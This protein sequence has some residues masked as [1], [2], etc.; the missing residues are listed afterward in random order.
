LG[1]ALGLEHE[2]NRS[3]RDRYVQV[4]PENVV[5]GMLH[6]FALRQTANCSRYDFAS[7]M[8]YGPT[9]FSS[10]GLAT[11][12]PQPEYAY[13]RDIMGL[14]ADLTPGDAAEVR[15]LYTGVCEQPDGGGGREGAGGIP[16]TDAST[17]D[18]TGGPRSLRTSDPARWVLRGS[19]V[20][21]ADVRRGWNEGLEIVTSARTADEQFVV[22]SASLPGVRQSFQ[23]AP[24]FPAEYVRAKWD[25]GY[26]IQH[27]VHGVGGWQVLMAD[28]LGWGAQSWRKSP[29]WPKEEIQAL[30][31]EGKRITTVAHGDGQ[32][33]VALTEGTGI[34]AQSWDTSDAPA[35]N[36][37]AERR[38]A[39]GFRVTGLAW[40][41]GSWVIVSS[42]GTDLDR[43][44]MYWGAAFP[45]QSIRDRWAEGY[46]ITAL[47]RSDAQ[48]VV[49]MSHR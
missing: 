38:W 16:T 7:V 8:H 28:G 33:F 23:D 17:G 9:F 25:E 20:P 47:A 30:W 35:P 44:T 41:G 1:H 34:S 18:D 21:A 31:D 29:N 5:S 3:D 14:Q 48:W 12:L 15:S 27:A 2:Q 43:Q 49:V 46:E 32:W 42:Q 37:V 39:D 6:N 13:A 22:M 24:E 4:F 10:N 19:T 45:E 40:G 11:L 26:R 36:E